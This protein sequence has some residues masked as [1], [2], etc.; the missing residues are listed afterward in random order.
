LTKEDKKV[1]EANRKTREERE[2]KEAQAK[3]DQIVSELWQE[4]K[5][6]IGKNKNFMTDRDKEQI[7]L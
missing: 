2:R 1:V 3:T 7:M 4:N 6:Y 5:N